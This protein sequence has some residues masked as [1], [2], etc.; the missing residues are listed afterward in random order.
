M[1]TP[2]C[3]TEDVDVGNIDMPRRA[4][5]ATDEQTKAYYVMRAAEEMDAI[6][7]QI[8][9]L[10]LNLTAGTADALILKKVNRM[11]ASGQIVVAAGSA[12]EDT[13]IHSWGYYHIKEAEKMLSLIF[14]G[15][16]VLDAE[17]KDPDPNADSRQ[18]GPMIKNREDVSYVDNFYGATGTLYPDG[19]SGFVQGTPSW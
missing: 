15:D 13:E 10:P 9:K 8:Y 19:Q 11:L 12:A 2:Y 1:T 14:K 18:T 17:Y 3:S 4:T 6:L 16:I 5:D 7:G